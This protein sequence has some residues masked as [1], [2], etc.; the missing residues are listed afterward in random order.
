[1]QTH[2]FSTI[3][4]IGDFLS[5][6]GYTTLRP[7]LTLGI[8]SRKKGMDCEAIHTHNMETDIDE[9]GQ[10]VNWLN[11]KT[12]KPL[13][14][15]GHS[16]GATQILAYL[17]R[18]Q[19]KQDS[20]QKIIFV[21]LAYFGNRPNSKAVQ[22]DINRARQAFNDGKTGLDSYGFTYCEKY[23]STPSDYLSYFKWSKAYTEAESHKLNDRLVLLFGS[24]DKRI[25]P[26]WPEDLKQ[27]GFDV[28]IVKDANH[29]FNDEYE[30]DMLDFL[31]ARIND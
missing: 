30:F 7:T 28:F 15:I 8:S 4:R 17:E 24:D 26:K 2:N 6:L 13:I 18:I 19:Y 27:S 20:I 5:D 22:S 10:W 25:D 29:F 3:Q 1:L 14:F 23:V 21:S 16:L 12:N 9:I 31:E 11:K